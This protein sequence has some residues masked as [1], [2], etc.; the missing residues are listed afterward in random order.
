M[1]VKQ[2]NIILL[3]VIVLTGNVLRCIFWGILS[4]PYRN[5]KADILVNALLDL[6]ALPATIIICGSL[7]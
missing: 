1:F 5:L 6:F 2:R 7:V 4:A 3:C